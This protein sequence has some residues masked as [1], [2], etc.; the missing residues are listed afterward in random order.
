MKEIPK[1]KH[2][3]GN[4]VS[5]CIFCSLIDNCSNLYCILF[6]VELFPTSEVIL[7]HN[8]CL[9]NE[10]LITTK[11]EREVN[12]RLMLILREKVEEIEKRL[13]ARINA[14]DKKIDHVLRPGD[15]S[16]PIWDRVDDL[17]RRLNI[18]DNW[19][20]EF[21]S[22]GNQ[23][24]RNLIIRKIDQFENEI[25][26][27]KKEIETLN[28][29]VTCNKLNDA[30]TITTPFA[31]DGNK[32]PQNTTDSTARVHK[33]GQLSEAIDCLEREANNCLT[34]ER[35]LDPII[36]LL[37]KVETSNKKAS[38]ILFTWISLLCKAE[39]SGKKID[40]PEGSRLFSMSETLY[41]RMVKELQY[42]SSLL[43]LDL[44]TIDERL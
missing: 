21:T 17:N 15:H 26:E 4:G 39:F 23:E 33:R 8:M 32:S 11:A 2:C 14:L 42:V 5:K 13:D 34:T 9:W 1:G 31:S 12:E 41:K 10:P 36:T 18:V 28:G 35:F 7:K 25:T 20:Y 27:I 37:E 24:T 40:E 30:S 38:E 19:V 16:M 3:E 43:S 44:P 22:D 6:D 29:V